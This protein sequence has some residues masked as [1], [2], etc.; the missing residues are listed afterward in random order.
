MREL[1][2]P[3]T[4]SESQGQAE[5]LT[6]H[7]AEFVVTADY[8][9]I[10]SQVLEL[11]KKSI[12]DTLAVALAGSVAE[13]STLIRRYLSELGLSEGPSTV[14][15][16]GLRLSPRF[17]ALANGAAMH[18]DDFDD[19]WQATPDRHQGVHPTAPVLAAVLALA[20]PEGRS[21]KDVLKASVVGIEAC[22]RLFDAASARHTT[23]GLH[24][25]GTS[26]MLGA[27]A[28]AANLLGLTVDVTR[29]VLGIAASQTGTLLAQL[30]TMTKP[31]HGGLAAECAVVSAD[32]A[33][34]GFTASPN[35]LETRWGYFQAMGG[36]H[37]DDRIRDKLGRPWAF[38]DRGVWLK[39]WP[40]GSLGHPSLTKTLDL[41]VEHDLR[42]PLIAGIRVRT[43]ESIRDVLFHHSPTSELEAK[44][45]LEF[46]I[47]ALLL[48]R[49]LTLR[50]FTDAF[51]NRPDV[52]AA[53][54]LVDYT[55][56]SAAEAEKGN[57][58]LVTSFV[59]VDL[60]DGGTV[61]GRIDYGKGSLANP[62]SEDEVAE[63]YRDCASFARWP[64]A[65]AERA[66]ELVRGLERLDDV[67]ELTACFAASSG[68]GAR[69]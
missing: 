7:V 61:G 24:S 8:V 65:K 9:D 18:A 26:A 25:T 35:I 38:A 12:L 4:S 29:Q 46:G 52:Q 44:F 63:K 51:V 43:S 45:S 62:L 41:I 69:P 6:A 2:E 16:S 47:A 31:F 59:E 32:L 60:V 37:D 22:C 64:K 67:R 14:F 5:S 49:K 40:T 20:E 57:Y 55:T 36:S 66:F 54:R 39:P 30:G 27:A 58:T 3:G 28:G 15:G 50:H 13:S 56:F 21:G 68:K 53:I 17:A 10:P 42:L 1:E 34:M 23:D 19:T 33:A 48:E 11:C